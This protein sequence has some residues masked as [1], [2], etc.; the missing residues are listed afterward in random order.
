M[1]SAGD[2]NQ[3]GTAVAGDDIVAECIELIESRKPTQ[4]IVGFKF[5]ILLSGLNNPDITGWTFWS[6]KCHPKIKN[7]E[8]K[9]TGAQFTNDGAVAVKPVMVD[10]A[11]S[12]VYPC[13]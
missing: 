3:H 7:W 9:M 1:T 2:W 6:G 10:G 4:T 12:G 5:S 8:I 13:P 11:V